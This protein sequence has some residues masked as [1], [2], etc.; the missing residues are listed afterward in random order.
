M[1][2][3]ALEEC[4]GSEYHIG[5][6]REDEQWPWGEETQLTGRAQ[7]PDFPHRDPNV[8][9][10]HSNYTTTPGCIKSRGATTTALESV[11]T[12]NI[13]HIKLQIYSTQSQPIAVRLPNYANI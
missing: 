6:W 13:W 5:E 9:I 7:N 10:S 11:Q 4:G 1:R 8:P 3:K 2:R 12:V